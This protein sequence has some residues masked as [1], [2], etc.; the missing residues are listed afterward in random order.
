MHTSVSHLT[1]LCENPFPIQE[2]CHFV[3]NEL[4]GVCYVD[5]L[6]DGFSA[7]YSFYDPALPKRSLGTWMIL[8]LI[9]KAR[10]LG[11]PYIYLGYYVRDCKSMAYKKKFIPNEILYPDGEWRKFLP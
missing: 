11:L 1:T 6:P 3:D 5:P 10:Q 8:A 9:E 2:W 7:V 4:A